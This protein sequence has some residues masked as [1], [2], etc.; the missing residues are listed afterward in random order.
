M[1]EL[2]HSGVQFLLENAVGLLDALDLKCARAYT[3]GHIFKTPF[4]P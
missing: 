3:H 2:V 1:S 4:P